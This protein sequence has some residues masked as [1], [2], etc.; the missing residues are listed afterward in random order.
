MTGSQ[1]LEICHAKVRSWAGWHAREVTNLL[2]NQCIFWFV[3]KLSFIT[4]N[5]KSVPLV[6]RFDKPHVILKHFIL[7]NST[8]NIKSFLVLD[9]T[10]LV[11][12]HESVLPGTIL[13]RKD[14]GIVAT[15]PNCTHLMQVTRTQQVHVFSETNLVSKLVSARRVGLAWDPSF[16]K[17]VIDLKVIYNYFPFGIKSAMHQHYTA[18][19]AGGVVHSFFRNRSLV[20]DFSPALAVFADTK[21][22]QIVKALPLLYRWNKLAG[23]PKKN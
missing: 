20:F 11:T 1:I 16:L 14:F 13:P 7:V 18:N 23:T 2:D 12:K 4:I 22:P 3:Y 21:D 15:F 19:Y 8:K 17:S 5:G 10:A 6:V 9:V